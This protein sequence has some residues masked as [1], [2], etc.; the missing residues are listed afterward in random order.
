MF[1][2][3]FSKQ[4]PIGSLLRSNFRVIDPRLLTKEIEHGAHVQLFFGPA[5]SQRNDG[6]VDSATTT[7]AR[8]SGDVTLAEQIPL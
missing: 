5:T 7:M 8:S 2:H 4:E 3:Q 1:G 6:Q